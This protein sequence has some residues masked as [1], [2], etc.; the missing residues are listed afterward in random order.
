MFNVKISAVTAACLL[1]MA[2]FSAPSIAATARNSQAGAY[3]SSTNNCAPTPY[4]RSGGCIS[5]AIEGSID[6]DDDALPPPARYRMRRP[7]QPSDE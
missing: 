7:V 6:D 1:S 3:G 4:F 5:S 2:S